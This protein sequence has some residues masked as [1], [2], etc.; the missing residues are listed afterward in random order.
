V[1]KPW[2]YR[3]SSSRV[4]ALGEP[5]PLVTESPCYLELSEEPSRRQALWRE[6]LWGGDVREEVVRRGDWALG[7]AAFVQRLREIHGRP[8]QRGR[9]R[10]RKSPAAVLTL[11][12]NA[13]L[14]R[15]G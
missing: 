7:D 6:F 15:M 4:Y 8:Q 10:P 2:E 13:P 9:G 5:D 1:A 12:Q 11:S 3:W 14:G